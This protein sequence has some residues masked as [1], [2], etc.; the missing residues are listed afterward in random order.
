MVSDEPTQRLADAAVRA[1]TVQALAGGVPS[2]ALAW[3]LAGVDAAPGWLTG[4]V[5]VVAVL[6]VVGL[7]VVVPRVRWRRWRYE[8]RDEQLDL[9]FGVWRTVRCVVPMARVQHVETQRTFF[10]DLFD[11]A[12]VTVHTAAGATTIP[13]LRQSDA[14]AMRDAIALLARVPDEP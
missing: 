6:V 10:S 2:L 7:V 5:R 4:L 14:D 11:L 1:W 12:E 13:A 9:R 8:L 3:W